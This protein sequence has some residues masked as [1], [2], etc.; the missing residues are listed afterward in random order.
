MIAARLPGLSFSALFICGA[1]AL[2]A[3][4]PAYAEVFADPFAERIFRA[5]TVKPDSVLGGAEDPAV[6]AAWFAR[7]EAVCPGM[8]SHVVY[9]KRWITDRVRAFLED[10]GRRVVVLGAGLDTL[11]L[12]LSGDYPEAL[13][14][15]IDQPLSQ[16]LKRGLA[17]NLVGRRPNLRFIGGDLSPARA[18]E[19]LA[20]AV[21]PTP[22][23]TIVV[24]EGV[25]E[26]LPPAA[27]DALFGYMRRLCAPDGRC[28][29]TFVSSK[30]T[31]PSLKVDRLPDNVHSD[32]YRFRLDPDGLDRYLARRALRRVALLD[33]ATA[34]RAYL[35]AVGLPEGEDPPMHPL[36]SLHLVEAASALPVA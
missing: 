8:A 14:V 22:A 30:V 33:P 31:L 16:G 7:H 1:V 12:R 6:V 21:P 2:A 13:F 29:F 9:R 15:E 23:R 18:G 28:L 20:K 34:R 4:H 25:A 11:A 35:P 17:A 3:R 10:G 26:Y 19:W 5:V 24:A 27:A 32:P 36:E